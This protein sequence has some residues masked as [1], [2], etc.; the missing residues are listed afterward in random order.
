MRRQKAIQG[1]ARL[2]K[3][4]KKGYHFVMLYLL[5][6]TLPVFGDLK[7]ADRYFDATL[8]KQA[9]L[10]YREEGK[11]EREIESLYL[12]EDYAGVVERLEKA[13]PSSEELYFLALAYQRL[14]LE[15]RALQAKKAYIHEGGDRE[16]VRLFEEE[17]GRQKGAQLIDQHRWEEAELI[18][19]SMEETPDI[20]YSLIK[21]KEA[22]GASR[23]ELKAVRQKLLTHYPASAYHA[24]VSF[25]LYTLQDYLL[26]EKEA[27][28]HL[29]QFVK[30]YKD[31]PYAICGWYLIGLDLKNERK[32]EGKRRIHHKSLE[33]SAD[34]FIE[35][36][37]LYDACE[38]HLTA[39]QKAYFFAL[40]QKAKLE[41]GRTLME[42][43][44]ASTGSKKHI[45]LMYA[46]DTL[47]SLS[48]PEA[49]LLLAQVYIKDGDPDAA[50]GELANLEASLASEKGPHLFLSKALFEKG[51]LLYAKRDIKEALTA[52]DQAEKRAPP[53]SLTADETLDSLIYKSLCL[54][55][56]KQYDQAM[57]I[58]S[59]V[60]NSDFVSSLRIKAMYM[61]ALIYEAE[62]RT[63]LAQRQFESALLKGGQWA[64][65]QQTYWKKE[66]KIEK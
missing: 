64:E 29:K 12:A 24:A 65:K 23:E 38:E 16:K 52:F 61:R 57:L 2:E 14:Q 6:L 17:I 8:Y 30:Q 13:S 47:N 45:Y 18:F 59:D 54:K 34:A 1:F 40:R 63:K 50:L 3:K 10:L 48:E 25:E 62:G 35:A 66:F 9:A 39:G 53:L 41:R 27:I 33:L 42:I 5:L 21:I 49:R 19:S 46:V 44:E 58:L 31:S 7:T 32:P 26:G 51:K 60:I 56:L 22:R 43:A 37:N 11:R 4:G 36:E 55:E 20:L 28:T 15:E